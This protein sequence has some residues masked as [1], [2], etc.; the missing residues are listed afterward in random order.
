MVRILSGIITCVLCISLSSF[1]QEQGGNSN[2]A[3]VN[4]AV[5]PN[6][7]TP[8]PEY[9]PSVIPDDMPDV[10]GKKKVK[11]E[12]KGDMVKVEKTKK[13]K[14]EEKKDEYEIMLPPDKPK[15][16]SDWAVIVNDCVPLSDPSESY[17]N[18]P[19]KDRTEEI[20]EKRKP[21]EKILLELQTQ[22]E[23]AGQ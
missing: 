23:T 9:D 1:S 18:V 10:N 19:E 14:V 20:K 4:E 13:A 11:V 17:L 22:M 8:G 12:A 5:N 16:N 6:D 3:P 21:K 7:F 15:D 2:I